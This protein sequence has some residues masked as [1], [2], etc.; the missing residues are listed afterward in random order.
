MAPPICMSLTYGDIP[1][2]GDANGDAYRPKGETPVKQVKFI[3]MFVIK[4][5]EGS[6]PCD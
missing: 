3:R 5:T 4:V 6:Y 2:K 1:P